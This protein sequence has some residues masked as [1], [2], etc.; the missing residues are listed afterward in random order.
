MVGRSIT[1]DSTFCVA[2]RWRRIRVREP[3]A[4]GTEAAEVGKTEWRDMMTGIE[5]ISEDDRHEVS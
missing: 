4:V 1:V 2:E 3:I 5:G